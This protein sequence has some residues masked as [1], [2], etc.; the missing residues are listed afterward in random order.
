MTAVDYSLMTHNR[1]DSERLGVEAEAKMPTATKRTGARTSGVTRRNRG[2]PT[3]EP[4]RAS[5][6]LRSKCVRHRYYARSAFVRD[7]GV[8]SRMAHHPLH[9]PLGNRKTCFF[10]KR[11]GRGRRN[12]L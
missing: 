12:R 4:V 5:T 7:Y 11:A 10:L 6:S 2:R 3:T 8:A 9:Q 1:T